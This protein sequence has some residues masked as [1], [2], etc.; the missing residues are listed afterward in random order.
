MLKINT[1]LQ[2]TLTVS[3]EVLKYIN[4]SDDFL[5]CNHQRLNCSESH[6]YFILVF[7]VNDIVCLFFRAK[8]ER[9]AQKE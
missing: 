2:N 5:F 7:F 6:L 4:E 9:Q 1:L 3:S 8:I